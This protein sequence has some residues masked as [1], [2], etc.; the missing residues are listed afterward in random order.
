VTPAPSAA[1]YRRLAQARERWH[2]AL[3]GL[4]VTA[5]ATLVFWLLPLPLP[6]S[7]PAPVSTGAHAAAAL[8]PAV[9]RSRRSEGCRSWR[10]FGEDRSGL[11][12]PQSE[13]Q[14]CDAEPGPLRTLAGFDIGARHGLEALRA[15]EVIV[16]S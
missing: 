14:V 6:Q 13:V 16:P 7:P 4:A 15:D 2:T 9:L 12:A 3:A 11:G 10:V 8:P 1:D 5:V